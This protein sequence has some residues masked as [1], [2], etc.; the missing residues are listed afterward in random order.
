MSASA[1]NLKRIRVEIKII[2]NPL[3]STLGAP[4]VDLAVSIPAV[5]AMRLT[6]S[7]LLQFARPI[8][9]IGGS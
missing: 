9:C 8:L 4:T 1:T 6:N 5:E 2:S 7:D 3:S